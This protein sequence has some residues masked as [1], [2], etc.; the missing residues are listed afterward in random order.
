MLRVSEQAVYSELALTLPKM[1]PSKWDATGCR[2]QASAEV[3]AGC[4]PSQKDVLTFEVDGCLHVDKGQWNKLSDPACPRLHCPQ[5]SQV[6]C[7][8]AGPIAVPKLQARNAWCC[9]RV[10]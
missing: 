6:P 1:D 4:C 7:P 3:S 2:M 10:L 9:R 5:G 8:G